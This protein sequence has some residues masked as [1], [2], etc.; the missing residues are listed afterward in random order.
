MTR[1][2]VVDDDAVSCQLLSDVLQRDETT[3]VRETDPAQ[4]IARL[5]SEP[6]DLAI[7]D[8]RMPGMNG[9]ELLRRLRERTPD[10]PVIIMTAFGSVDTAVQ[11]IASGAID[12]LSKPMDVDQ[13][14]RAVAKALSERTEVRANLPGV[15]EVAG[16]TGRSTAMVEVYKAIARVAPSRS[17]VLILGES[18]TGKEMVA[19]AIH[20][21]SPRRDRSF[22]AVD[23]A[24]L[25]ETLLESELFGHARGAFTGALADKPGLFVE[26]DGGTLFL[27]EIGDISPAMQMKLLR[28]LQEQQVRPVGGSQWRSIDVRVIA[29]THRDLQSA[30]AAARFREDLYYRINVF[31]IRLPPLRER[32]EDV[33]LLVEHLI[34]RAARESGKR[35]TGMSQEA[36][37][38]LSRYDW[39]GNVRELAH[40]IERS[41]V[42]AHRETI[43]LDE[44]PHEVRYP[45]TAHPTDILGDRP[46]LEELKR[47]YIQRVVDQSQGNITRAAAIL[48][49]DRRSLYRMLQRYGMAVR[50]D[51]GDE[52]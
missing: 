15:E 21:H 11:A 1:I 9:L 16:I 14:R 43:G 46:T 4:V 41:V 37:E 50:G 31:N 42:L 49:V 29:A 27:D 23:C 22:I 44:L 45:A 7:L 12:Y 47:R 6:V 17:T 34:R 24:A 18:G 36:L 20:E 33:P 26:A 40:V 30:V 8:V 32:R 52:G 19:R 25:T 3:V 35:V 10:L 38:L 48:G 28:V 5:E 39:P 13:I 51:D 2:L